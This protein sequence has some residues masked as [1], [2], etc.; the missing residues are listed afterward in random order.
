MIDIVS[1]VCRDNNV[2]VQALDFRRSSYNF[3]VGTPTRLAVQRMFK[4]ESHTVESYCCDA[5]FGLSREFITPKRVPH[6]QRNCHNKV[7][8]IPLVV[9]SLVGEKNN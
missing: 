4:V 2:A 6:L 1:K 3:R 8:R 5:S 7:F 9:R